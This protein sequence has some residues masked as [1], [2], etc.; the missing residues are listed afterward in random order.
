MWI[1]FGILFLLTG[2]V[3]LGQGIIR[4]S[5]SPGRWKIKITQ[6]VVG[7]IVISLSFFLLKNAEGAGIDRLAIGILLILISASIFTIGWWFG[8]WSPIFSWSSQNSNFSQLLWLFAVSIG[9]FIL[10]VVIIGSPEISLPI[11]YESRYGGDSFVVQSI[12]TIFSHNMDP[13]PL[14]FGAFAIII[15]IL[16]NGFAVRNGLNV[17]QIIGANIVM[18][19]CMS[20]LYF[21]GPSIFWNW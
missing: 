4:R 7:F 5:T 1:L 15:F 20:L 19:G 18:S 17:K 11:S 3:L 2:I 21:L 16:M 9:I 14:S 8:F 6:I 10:G 12:K 13:L